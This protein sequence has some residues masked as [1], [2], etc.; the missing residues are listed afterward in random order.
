MKSL[1]L[2]FSPNKSWETDSDFE[3]V[4]EDGTKVD[5]KNFQN[6]IL[7]KL[8]LVTFDYVA[9]IPFEI[10]DIANSWYY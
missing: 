3:Y 4:F 9:S 6:Y 7:T 10:L 1:L 8:S 2:K 5:Q